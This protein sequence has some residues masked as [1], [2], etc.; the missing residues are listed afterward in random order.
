MA[1]IQRVNPPQNR[2]I[3]FHIMNFSGGL[4][5]RSTLTANNEGANMVNMMFYDDTVLEKRKG[6][7]LVDDKVFTEPMTH[8][9]EYEPYNDNPQFVRAGNTSM[10]INN[11]GSYNTITLEGGTGVDA[12]NYLGRYMFVDGVNLRAYGKFPQTGSTYERI[13]G[14]PTASY[15]DLKV[16]STPTT[17]TALDTTHVRGVMVY[18]YTNKKVWYEPCTNEKNDPYLGV[19]AVPENPRFLTSLKGRLYVSG[20]AKDDD[21]VFISHA[22]NPFYFPPSMPL[23]VPPNSDSVTGLTVYDNSVL[24]GRK[25]D[26]HVI[27]GV[28]N[29]PDLGAEMFE[30][31]RLN[32]HTG[33]MNNKCMNVAHNFLFFIGYDGNAYGMSNSRTVEKILATQ[34]LNDNLDF[35][36]FPFGLDREDMLTSCTLFHDNLWYVSIQGFVFVYNYKLRAWTVLD[37]LDIRSF[38]SKDYTLMWGNEAGQLC[39]FSDHYLDQGKPYLAFWESGSIDFDEP[40][41]YKQ[42]R[43]VFIL[44][45]SYTGYESD[46]RVGFELD[47]NDIE[48]QVSIP[49]QV[50]RFGTARFGDRYSARNTNPSLPFT[51]GRRARN[52]KIRL[53]NSYDV[54]G[55]VAS[56]VELN[57]MQ[58]MQ[59]EDTYYNTGDSQYYTWHN[60]SRTWEVRSVE[61]LNQPM[62]VFQVNGEYELRGKR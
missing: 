11:N 23:Q 56:T 54:K 32:T 55:N 57:S 19:S 24:V 20:N 30:L 7:Q 49:N 48:G 60:L 26:I 16:V 25:R 14:T 12:E 53:A 28:T 29:N 42:F 43:D 18:D 40:S 51:V 17:Y 44:A 9:G 50:A 31:K 15:I 37:N 22:G 47:F 6:S 21:N 61:K 33:F 8:L 5:N 36:G 4:N 52:I 27:T 58:G 1:F 39:E 38:H 2:I 46:I 13:V 59:D 34:M 35:R 3:P 62:R 45:Y 41:T 10:L